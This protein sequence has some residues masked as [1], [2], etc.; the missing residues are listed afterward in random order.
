MTEE[1]TTTETQ[2]PVQLSYNDIAASLQ[3]IDVCV[4]RGAIR[5]EEMSSVGA[6]RDRLSA[7]IEHSK[8]DEEEAPSS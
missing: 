1:V 4:Q 3:I 7:F 5:G 8:T 6:I 2:E